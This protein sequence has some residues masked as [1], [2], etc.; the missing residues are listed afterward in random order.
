MGLIQLFNEACTMHFDSLVRVFCILPIKFEA[1]FQ[2]TSMGQ[3]VECG[4]L[5]STFGFQ[6]KVLPVAEMSRKAQ[7]RSVS[8]FLRH[9]AVLFGV[10]SM[11]CRS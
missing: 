1:S 4:T 10:R 8:F 6:Q 9:G 3:R 2:E 11:L 7:Y 5:S